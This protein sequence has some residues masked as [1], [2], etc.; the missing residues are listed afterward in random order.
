M[1]LSTPSP[2]IPSS[3]YRATV[4]DF[5]TKTEHTEM[6]CEGQPAH[7]P[8][9]LNNMFLHLTRWIFLITSTPKSKNFQ[10][11][12][13]SFKISPTCCQHGSCQQLKSDQQS[14]FHSPTIKR[15]RKGDPPWPWLSDLVWI[16]T[17][18]GGRERE[19]KKIF[20]SARIMRKP[21]NNLWLL[22]D[23]TSLFGLTKIPE[24]MQSHF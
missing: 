9:W 5:T 10:Q 6:H 18:V 1:W 7:I 15:V 17:K 12:D 3:N 4:V 16:W 19:K 13:I 21:Q 23:F 2:D 24:Y 11:P 22:R 20:G 14:I 8:S